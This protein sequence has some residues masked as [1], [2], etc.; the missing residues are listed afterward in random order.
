[1]VEARYIVPFY[2]VLSCIV[3]P[4]GATE[5]SGSVGRNLSE[6]G[7]IYLFPMPEN[8]HEKTLAAL[9]VTQPGEVAPLFAQLLTQ[10]TADLQ[11]AHSADAFEKFRVQWLGR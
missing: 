6:F 7:V 11:A 9:G 5:G 8:S 2:R 3:I 1:V 4:S 10:A